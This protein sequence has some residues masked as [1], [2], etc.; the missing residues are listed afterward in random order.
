MIR[1]LMRQDDFGHLGR[2][3]TRCL[4][5]G[6]IVF[7]PSAQVCRRFPVPDTGGRLLRK[8]CIDQNDVISGIDHIDSSGLVAGEGLVGIL[9]AVLTVIKIGGSSLAELIDIS[10]KIGLGNIGGAAAYL[11]LAGS[12]L[13]FVF[14]GAKE[15]EEGPDDAC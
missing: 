2:L 15:N 6:Y 3:I 10:G 5:R 7:D 9:L 12:M 1:V 11:L 14:K 8:S 4:Q 13:L